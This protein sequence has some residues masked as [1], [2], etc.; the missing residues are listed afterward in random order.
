MRQGSEGGW[1]ADLSF[2]ASSGESLGRRS[3]HSNGA[4]CAA[5]ADP[6]SLVIALMVESG[7]AQAT[8]QV[9]STPAPAPSRSA[10]MSAALVVSSGLLPGLSYGAGVDWAAALGSWLS[11][12]VGSSVFFPDSTTTSGRGGEF[13]SWIGG[14][15]LCSRVFST[16][17]TEGEL[18]AGG[19]GGA[20]HGVGIGLP[21]P[22]SKTKPYGDAE[23]HAKVSF[24]VAGS[25]S[26]VAQLGV[27]V[28]WLR[29]RFVYLDAQNS[30]PVYEP[31]KAIPFASIGIELGGGAHSYV[32]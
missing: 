22:W 21:V 30:V 6:V 13:W 9:R 29:S 25:F 16:S 19:R 12:Q 8:L 23:V 10:S 2:A 31:D 15:A 27:A 11:L 3:L 32:Q 14:V 17:V 5:L 4:T 20:I 1:D 28:P 18:C 7:E 24:P 26:A